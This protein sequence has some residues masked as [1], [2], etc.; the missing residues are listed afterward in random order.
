MLSQACAG[1]LLRIPRPPELAALHDQRPSAAEQASCRVQ[2]D[3]AAISVP[4]FWLLVRL[5]H[6]GVPLYRPM[7]GRSPLDLA[8]LSGSQVQDFFQH[9]LASR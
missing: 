6:S 7:L 9:L 8:D 1:E 4:K 5:A 2:N 3:T